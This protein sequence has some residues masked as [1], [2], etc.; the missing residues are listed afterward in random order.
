MIDALQK[1]PGPVSCHSVANK[2][3]RFAI[4]ESLGGVWTE[5]RG[6][7]ASVRNVDPKLVA[8]RDLALIRLV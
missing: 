6:V 4:V 7:M 1:V 2:L 5:E 8:E 3:S